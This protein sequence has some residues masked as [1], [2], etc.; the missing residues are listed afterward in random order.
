MPISWKYLFGEVVRPSG[1]TLRRS[2]P[3]MR[4]A[5]DRTKVIDRSGKVSLALG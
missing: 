1:H 4:S 5:V 3:G 2:D